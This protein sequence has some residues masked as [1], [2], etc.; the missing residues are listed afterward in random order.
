M[1]TGMRVRFWV[2][3]ALTAC[4]GALAALTLVWRDWLEAIFGTDP[5]RHS[6]S[7]EWLVVAILLVV[8]LGAGA[9]AHAEW[10]RVATSS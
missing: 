8:A 9:L 4:S 7:L 10:R 2:E 5:D 6:G 1:R 3:A